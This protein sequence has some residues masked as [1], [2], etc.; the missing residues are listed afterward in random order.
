MSVRRFKGRAASVLIV[1]FMV[2]LHSQQPPA[3][4]DLSPHSTQ[5]VTVDKNVRLEVLDWGGSGNPLVLLAGGGD[6]A[7]VFDDFPLEGS[8]CLARLSS[9]IRITLGQ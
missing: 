3:W 8:Y 4:K 2:P 5:F 6:T 1:S 7:H 9:S